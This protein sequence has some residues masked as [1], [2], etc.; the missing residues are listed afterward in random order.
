MINFNWKKTIG[1]FLSIFV[2]SLGSVTLTGCDAGEEE[3]EIES[4]GEEIEI[5]EDDGEIEV[6][7]D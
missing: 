1:L 2:L 6:E 7:E 3:V 5:E 4:G